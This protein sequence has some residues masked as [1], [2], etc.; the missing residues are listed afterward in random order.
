LAGHVNASMQARSV[1]TSIYI[2]RVPDLCG[3]LMA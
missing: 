2:G 3:E 1:A